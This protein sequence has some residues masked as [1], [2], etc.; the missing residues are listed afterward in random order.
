MVGSKK[1]ARWKQDGSKKEGRF[2]IDSSKGI[3]RG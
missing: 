1:V 2:K 3:A